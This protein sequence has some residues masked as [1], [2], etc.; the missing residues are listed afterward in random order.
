MPT[1]VLEEGRQKLQSDAMAAGT[2]R[3][4]GHVG[5]L[6]RR[7]T[8]PGILPVRPVYK[9]DHPPYTADPYFTPSRMQDH[10]Q[11]IGDPDLLATNYHNSS[12]QDKYQET[13]TGA[14]TLSTTRPLML[15]DE[16]DLLVLKDLTFGLEHPCVLDLKMGTRQH[17]VFAARQKMES[18]TRKCRQSTSQTI[19]VRVC[20]MQVYKP[21]L[22]RCSV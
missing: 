12:R 9:S 6:V 18:Q 14:S 5:P 17:G 16:Q 10:S 20:G 4:T 2:M 8:T 15:D 21:K 3:R 22:R 19:S 11:I 1:I 7:S 13:I